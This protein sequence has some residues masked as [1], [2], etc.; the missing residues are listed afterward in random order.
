M[1]GFSHRSLFGTV[2]ILDNAKAQRVK[3]G[4]TINNPDARLTDVN[5]KWLGLKATCQICAARR[6]VMGD[7]KFPKHGHFCEGGN[8]LPLEKDATLA[9]SHLAH[10]KRLRA[11]GNGSVTRQINN[12]EKKIRLYQHYQQPRAMWQLNTTF[13]TEYAE[14]VELLSHEVLA[15][16]LDKLAPIGEVFSCSAAEASEAIE[17]VLSELGLLEAV[18]KE[19]RNDNTSKEYGYC[20]MC[21]ENLTERGACLKCS[22]PFFE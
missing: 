2:Y 7:K 9:K 3:V 13:Y 12:L 19:V 4:T 8:A 10:M 5:D 6:I 1:V 16:H 14:H 11:S 20:S 17:S 15:D 22:R 21:G 18:R